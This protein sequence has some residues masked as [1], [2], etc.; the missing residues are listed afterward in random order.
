MVVA[1]KGFTVS[2]LLNKIQ[3]SL[4]MPPFKRAGQN[5]FTTGEALRMSKAANL[6]ARA[7]RAFERTQKYKIFD[8][9]LQVNMTDLAAPLFYVCSTPSTQAFCTYA[10]CSPCLAL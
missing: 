2:N 4:Y 1:G 5:Q 9:P 6:R 7:E 10:Q 8:R 3:V